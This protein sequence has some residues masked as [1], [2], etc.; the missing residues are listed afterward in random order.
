MIVL[1][2]TYDN[3]TA[4]VT[5]RYQGSGSANATVN[6]AEPTS[7]YHEVHAF[8]IERD[9]GVSALAIPGELGTMGDSCMEPPVCEVNS[10]SEYCM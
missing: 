5:K 3:I 10:S 2:G 4:I 8:D 6:V 7:C 1:M 9:G